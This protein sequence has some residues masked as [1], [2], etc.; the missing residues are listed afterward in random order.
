MQ[1]GELSIDENLAAEL[2]AHKAAIFSFSSEEEDE[3]DMQLAMLG[4]GATPKRGS[5]PP[6]THFVYNALNQDA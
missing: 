1:D 3:D 4:T 5:H 2:E 6:H